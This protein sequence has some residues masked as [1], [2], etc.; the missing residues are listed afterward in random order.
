MRIS[1]FSDVHLEFGSCTFPDG[2]TD[3]IVAAGDIAP[4]LHSL[5]WLAQAPAPVVYV[6]GNHEY[7]GQ[8][9]GVTQTALRQARHNYPNINFLEKDIYEDTE[10]GVRVLGTTLWSNF[11]EANPEVLFRIEHMMNDFSCI[12]IGGRQLTPIDLLHIHSGSV[13]WLME[14]LN[15]PYSGKTVVVTHHAPSMLSWHKPDIKGEQRYGYC[16]D[17]EDLIE[18]VDVDLWIHG[19]THTEHLYYVGDTRIACKARG[20]FNIDT[21]SDSFIPGNIVL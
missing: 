18:T 11:N 14:K 4:G 8:D 7:Y 19:H 6:A 9:M 17:M 1:Y 20:Y 3:L 16:T 21:D 15:E 5:P 13:E 12:Y 10:H 2:E